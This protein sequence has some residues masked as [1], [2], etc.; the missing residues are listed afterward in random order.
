MST[1]S[2]LSPPASRSAAFSREVTAI[3]GLETSRAPR[4]A[5]ARSR[6]RAAQA[7]SGPSST[8]PSASRTA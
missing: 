6:A 8:G 4:A 7:G 5:G 3:R 2:A 1:A